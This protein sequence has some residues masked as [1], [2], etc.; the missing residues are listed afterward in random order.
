[1]K[2]ISR[3]RIMFV[4]D[5][6]SVIK[7][8]KRTFRKYDKEWKMYFFTNPLE[9]FE[10]LKE[11]NVDVIITDMKMPEETGF[12]LLSKVKK[13]YPGII[14][15]ILTGYAN[16][17]LIYS[18]F[19]VAH[20]LLIK[21]IS[22]ESIIAVV[23][24]INII[25]TYIKNKE[26]Q[27]VINNLSYLPPLPEIYLELSKKIKDP[28]SSLNDLAKII[29]RDPSLIADIL[30]MV[31]SAYFGLSNKVF[32]ISQAISFMGID[33]IKDIILT[34]SI[35]KNLKGTE[36]QIAAIKK[37]YQHSSNVLKYSIAI[38]ENLEMEDIDKNYI[39]ITSMFHDLGKIVL[40]MNLG[41]KYEVLLNSA[42]KDKNLNL[43]ELEIKY[44]S[45]TH[46]QVGAYILGLWGFSTK[47]IQSILFH[48]H[49]ELSE[50][51]DSYLL[52]TIYLADY[53]DN[54]TNPNFKV[55]LNRKYLQLVFKDINIDELIK[56][57]RS[58][59]E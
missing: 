1:M 43:E 45:F 18:S 40:I 59:N 54:K 57:V 9:A 46:S 32:K 53:L 47:V 17:E 33:L 8:L 11:N 31:N 39:F 49:P 42:E 2:E 24:Q 19:E 34:S 44:L 27:N 12:E 36:T 56:K 29:S 23:T 15:I 58:E 3:L 35:F 7:S 10:S 21:P 4:D 26:L 13:K 28:E 37:V 55:E 30:K 14:R 51:T 48:H 20:Q 5:E 52:G 22:A 6:L 16:K 38:S 41:K 50:C 25:N